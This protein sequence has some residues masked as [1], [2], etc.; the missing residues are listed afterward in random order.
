MDKIEYYAS[1]LN[2][3]C[4]GVC[5]LI[6]AAYWVQ[7]LS[8]EVYAFIQVMIEGFSSSSYYIKG[9]DPASPVDFVNKIL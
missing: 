1:E 3:L 6:V 4:I 2:T 5:L 7:Q 8:P 9:I